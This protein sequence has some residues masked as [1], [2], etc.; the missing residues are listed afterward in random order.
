MVIDELGVD[1][2]DGAHEALAS[3]RERWRIA[4]TA[5]AVRDCPEVAARVL[6][7]LDYDVTPPTTGAPERRTEKLRA[8]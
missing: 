1:Y 4:Q 7:D 6:R 8:I 5:A 3:G 2:E